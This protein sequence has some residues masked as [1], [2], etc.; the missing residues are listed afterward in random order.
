ME[1]GDE[2]NP[3]REARMAGIRVIS[4]DLPGALRGVWHMPSRTVILDS[5]L[6]Q[7]ERRSVLCHE[8]VHSERGDAC[9]QSARVEAEVHAVAARRLVPLERLVDALRW[10]RSESCLAD[11]LWVDE[12]I[13]RARLDRLTEMERELVA[14]ALSVEQ[15]V[16][17]RPA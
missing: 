9:R 3:W 10:A 8:L 6:S 14:A 16:L 5:G 15:A 11:E 7:R 17:S 13:V 2:Y 4:R 1:S 12:T